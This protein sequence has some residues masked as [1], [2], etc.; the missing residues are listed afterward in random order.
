MKPQLSS[1]T[2]PKPFITIC[3]EFRHIFCYL[4]SSIRFCIAFLLICL[5][6]FPV[7]LTAQQ[8]LTDAGEDK[9]GHVRVFEFA[10]PPAKEEAFNEFSVSPDTS[11]AVHTGNA[12]F[13]EEMY[14]TE[15]ELSSFPTNER[16]ASEEGDLL[17]YPN[18]A[19]TLLTVE[20][21]RLKPDLIKGISSN[22]VEVFALKNNDY[23]HQIDISNLAAG[24]YQ[25]VAI[26]QDQQI[27]CSAFVKVVN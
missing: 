19:T 1:S 6:P 13:S 11:G 26:T 7:H 16:W 24:L 10:P 2:N 9:A 25:L 12:H 17:L 4:R 8:D 18:P 5:L 14:H 23:H 27:H 3:F 15:V 22:G 20:Y 21:G